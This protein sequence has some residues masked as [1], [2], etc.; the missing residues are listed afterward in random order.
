MG[1][2]QRTSNG[3]Y[4]STPFIES[5]HEITEITKN[6]I[7]KFS[8]ACAGHRLYMA[9]LKNDLST[10]SRKFKYEFKKTST[11]DKV[12]AFMYIVYMYQ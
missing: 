12:N 9:F 8:R 11:S 1:A 3:N 5:L 7:I 10:S 6:V 4:R 2:T